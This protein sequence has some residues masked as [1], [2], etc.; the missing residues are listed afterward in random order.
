MRGD[1]GTEVLF[2]PLVLPLGKSISLGVECSRQVLFDPELLSDGFPK[3]R[4]ETGVSIADDFGRETE[5]SVYVVK[6]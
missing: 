6:V 2:D 5:P 3:V 1:N 4:S